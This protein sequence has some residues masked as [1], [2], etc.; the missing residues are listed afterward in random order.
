MD[1]PTRKFAA[2]L[3]EAQA[4]YHHRMI[5]EIV[6]VR[7]E[8]TTLAPELA[9]QFEMGMVWMAAFLTGRTDYDVQQDVD[10]LAASE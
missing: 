1:E 5:E 3:E 9:Q 10:T 4:Q 2:S 7:R 6:R 8:Q